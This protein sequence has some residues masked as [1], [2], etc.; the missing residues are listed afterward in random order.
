MNCKRVPKFALPFH[1]NKSPCADL[2]HEV[3]KA[4]V[5][6]CCNLITLNLILSEELWCGKFG[7]NK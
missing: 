3:N 4:L 7:G 5:A 6:L 2:S 1:I